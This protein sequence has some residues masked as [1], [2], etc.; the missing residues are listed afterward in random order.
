[1]AEGLLY[2]LSDCIHKDVL[3]PVRDVFCQQIFFD[4]SIWPGYIAHK[5]LRGVNLVA[6]LLLL[7]NFPFLKN[8]VQYHD[9]RRVKGELNLETNLT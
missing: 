3:R 9:C 8:G 6:Q 7:G 1:M 4:L 5:A 2:Y